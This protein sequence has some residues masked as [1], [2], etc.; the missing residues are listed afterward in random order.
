MY[1]KLSG[2]DEKNIIAIPPIITLIKV[3]QVKSTINPP[4]ILDITFKIDEIISLIVFPILSAPFFALEVILS[5][6]KFENLSE[7][8]L[9]PSFTFFSIFEMVIGSPFISN[10]C[11][12]VTASGIKTHN[13]MYNTNP[14]PKPK[15]KITIMILS[16]SGSTPK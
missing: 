12:V 15:N 1:K 14:V 10:F 9:N 2:I 13:I 4:I 3:I 16:H 8:S 6:S 7:I 11:E 5:W